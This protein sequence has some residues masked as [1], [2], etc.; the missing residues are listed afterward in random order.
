MQVEAGIGA[1]LL[2]TRCC[3]R[4]G[5]AATHPAV[6]AGAS[7]GQVASTM[8]NLKGYVERAVAGNIN[9]MQMIR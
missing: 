1:V 2:N 6:T 5:E 7:A 9:S 8:D 4:Y 3:L